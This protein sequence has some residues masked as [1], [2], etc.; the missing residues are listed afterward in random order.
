[1]NLKTEKIT[2]DA[3]KFVVEEDSKEIGRAFLYILKNDLH[4]EPFGLM[5]DVFVDETRRGQGLGRKL[6]EAVIE[7][8]KSRGCYKLICTSRNSNPEVHEFYKKFGFREWGK[9]FRIDLR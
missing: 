9:E 4:Q 1:M 8:A 3:I 6:V 5:E 7:G 2:V